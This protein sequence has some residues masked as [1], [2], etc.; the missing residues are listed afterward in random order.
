MGM[1]YTGEEAQENGIVH[2]ITC[3]A[4]LLKTSLTLAREVTK[5]RSLDRKTLSTLKQDLLPLASKL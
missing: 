3:N 1:K 2:K 4:D 5:N